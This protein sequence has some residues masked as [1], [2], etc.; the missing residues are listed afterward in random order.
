MHVGE[1]QSHPNGRTGAPLGL[2]RAAEPSVTRPRRR[3]RAAP[4]GWLMPPVLLAATACGVLLVLRGPERA[5][6]VSAG[7]ALA[8]VVLW[9]LVSIFLPARADRTCPACGAE[10]LERLDPRTTH[11]ILCA[12]CGLRDAEQSSFLLAE[13]EGPL[14]RIVL[15]ERSLRRTARGGGGR[16]ARSTTEREDSEWR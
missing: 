11:G 13:E 4:V 1:S 9:V 2:E 5:F 3:R 16:G 10:S 8:L 14:E 12:R 15:E 6:V 7:I